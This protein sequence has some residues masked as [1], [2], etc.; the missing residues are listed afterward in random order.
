MFGERV[1]EYGYPKVH[2]PRNVVYQFGPDIALGVKERF[3]AY[4]GTTWG[5]FYFAGPAC[6]GPSRLS[7]LEKTARVRLLALAGASGSRSARSPAP[8]LGR[9]APAASSRRSTSGSA[10]GLVAPPRKPATAHSRAPRGA[11]A[12]STCR[13]VAGT[14]SRALRA[15]ARRLLPL[16]DLPCA[17]FAARLLASSAPAAARRGALSDLPFAARRC[18]RA[19]SSS[20][21]SD[22]GSSRA[23]SPRPA[24]LANVDGCATCP[25]R[26]ARAAVSRR[27][28]G[29]AGSAPGRRVAACCSLRCGLR[30]DRRGPLALG[31]TVVL[32]PLL[33]APSCSTPRA[34]VAP[35]RW[36]RCPASRRAA[37]GV[38]AARARASSLPRS[39]RWRV[40]RRDPHALMRPRLLVD[41]LAEFQRPEAPCRDQP[42]EQALCTTS[43]RGVVGTS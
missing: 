15:G 8:A 38:P 20:R 5:H 37:V 29:R 6:A 2:G 16:P 19:T 32:G 24:R 11:I 35:A 39:P 17:Y 1:L 3:D 7:T 25:P 14:L 36:P 43:A 12:R 31:A 23:V 9:I 28:R 33:S 4:I 13:A 26:A 27:R 30:H 34:R 10:P 21:P 18:R 41:S 42:R 22:R 40:P